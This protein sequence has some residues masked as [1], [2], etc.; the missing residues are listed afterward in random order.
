MSIIPIPSTAA[1]S[2]ETTSAVDSFNEAAGD[3]TEALQRLERE[4]ASLPSQT[5]QPWQTLLKRRDEL[6]GAVFTLRQT[7]LKSEVERQRL[8]K[9]V[10][11]ELTVGRAHAEKERAKV[12]ATVEGKLKKTGISP[13]TMPG[14][15]LNPAA[16]EARFAYTVRT[17][18]EAAAAEAALQQ[19]EADLA[20][21]ARLRHEAEAENLAE[22]TGLRRLAESWLA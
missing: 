10:E 19:V 7:L 4:L 20:T 17:S 12:L 22:T 2:P 3:N 21:V 1:L 6:R 18:S 15:G 5:D 8:L 13:Q 11:A 14:W 16:A 9:I